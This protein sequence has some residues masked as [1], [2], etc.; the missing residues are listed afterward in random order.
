MPRTAEMEV[1]YAASLCPPR[2][3]VVGLP[4]RTFTMGHAVLLT[5]M[6]NPMLPWIGGVVGIGNWAQFVLVCLFPWSWSR[7]IVNSRLARPMMRVLIACRSGDAAKDDAPLMAFIRWHLMD[8]PELHSK[9]GREAT[10]TESESP[11]VGYLVS[12]F[13]EFGVPRSEVLDSSYRLLRWEH[14]ICVDR[15]GH[16]TL[17]AKIPHEVRV[18]LIELEVER[19]RAAGIDLEKITHEA[20][21]VNHA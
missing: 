18:K 17:K 9:T 16:Q 21:G 19:A 20:Y 12:R 8:G 1:E 6:G 4:L 14:S 10:T 7:R 5:A 3:R 13:I 15:A 2:F 11:S